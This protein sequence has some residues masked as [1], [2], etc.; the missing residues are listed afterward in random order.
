M[1]PCQLTEIRRQVSKMSNWKQ[2]KT[3]WNKNKL[4]LVI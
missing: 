3:N 2:I 1:L 4:N